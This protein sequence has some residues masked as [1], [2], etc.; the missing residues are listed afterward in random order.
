MSYK[1][2]GVEWN[3]NGTLKVKELT[4]LEALQVLIDNLEYPCEEEYNIV[5]KSLKALEIIKNKQVYIRQLAMYKNNLE[6][7]N[8]EMSENRKLTEEEFDLLKEVLL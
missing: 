7:Y 3:D 2:A 4:P 5:W 8:T 1:L 6:F